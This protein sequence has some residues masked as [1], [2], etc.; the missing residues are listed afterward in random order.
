MTGILISVTSLLLSVAILLMGHGLQLTV[1][2]L[3]AD[4]LGWSSAT[5]GY[6]GS[7]YFVGF[8]LGC[9]TIPR[10]VTRVGHIRVFGVLA[11]IATAALLSIAVLEYQ[12]AWMIARLTTGWCFA[13]LYMVIESWL[14]ERTSA[15]N[16][17]G[18]LSVYTVITLVAICVGQA[19]I[20]LELSYFQL[21]VVAAILISLG[22]IP[23][24]LTSSPA[25]QPIPAVSFRLK[26]VYDA[27]HVA[28]VG[29]FLGGFVT[30]GFWSL[31]P[32]VARAQGLSA[33]QIGVFM[34]V[35]I[36]GGAVFQLP[37][38][39]L[40]DR[41]DRRVVIL[42]VAIA[43]VSMS[44]LA[45]LLGQLSTAAYFVAMFIF[46]GMTFPLYSLCLAHANDN[47]ELPLMEVA[48]VI[49]LMNSAGSVLGPLIVSRSLEFSNNGLFMVAASAL[50]ILALWTVARMRLHRV[51]REFFEPFVSLPRTTHRV[52]DLHEAE[53][54]GV[55]RS[56]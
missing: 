47:T 29:A 27:S 17:G 54:S 7:S 26:A 4:Q 12:A 9:L 13:G 56:N 32:I 28:V 33:D 6:I 5:I 23:V 45:I 21:A 44:V 50:G 18:I 35:T 8:V 2:P 16:R 19:F 10:L 53:E 52:V 14:N 36:L 39:K 3:Y 48:S 42:G 31:G 40:S 43:G 37:I 22:T 49:L 15:E 25:P 24:G 34:A 55:E 38:G 30:G 20:G 1:V 51:A 46:G 11:S 41:Y